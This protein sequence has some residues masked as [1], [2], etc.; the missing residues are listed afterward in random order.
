MAC[1]GRVSALNQDNDNKL[2]ETIVLILGGGGRYD[3][4]SAQPVSKLINIKIDNIDMSC[5]PHRML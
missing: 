2:L 3:T 4:F 5:L 1:E